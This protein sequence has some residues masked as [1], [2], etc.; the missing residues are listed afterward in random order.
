MTARSRDYKLKT[1]P[2]FGYLLIF[3]FLIL[4]RSSGKGISWQDTESTAFQVMLM[5]G[6]YLTIFI[7]MASLDAAMYSD[8]K[9]AAWI[10]HIAP[11]KAPGAI[12]TGLVK[13]ILCKFALPIVG[14][15]SLGGLYFMGWK[16]IPNL[17]LAVGMIL[18]Y[19]F[20]FAYLTFKELP[21]SREELDNR[22]GASFLVRLFL[23]GLIFL[24]GILHYF[25]LSMLPLIIL[26][27]LLSWAA[28][29]LLYQSLYQRSLPGWQY[30]EEEEATV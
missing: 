12:L 4:F 23:G 17:F 10:Y 16:F 30:R 15:L 21:F 25:I 5:S 1:Y 26:L 2:S 14:F 29:W 19:S 20:L 28:C 27:S 18:S 24:I 3:I 11:V 22:K 8:K 7:I 13:S 6:I 9:K